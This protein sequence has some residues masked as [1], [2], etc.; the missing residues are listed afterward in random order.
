V[1]NEATDLS[2]GVQKLVKETDDESATAEAKK[3]EGTGDVES[4]ESS[5][6]AKGVSKGKEK[7]VVK[8]TRKDHG[9]LKRNIG[10]LAS[11]PSS[12]P[13]SQLPGAH[14]LSRDR[15]ACQQ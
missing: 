1:P 8:Q 10:R 11:S 5:V 6:K 3:A 15:E 14:W 7:K 9:K 13:P 2:V 4:L 12:L